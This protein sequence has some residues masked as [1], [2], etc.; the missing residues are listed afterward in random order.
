MQGIL[1]RD[2]REIRTKVVPNVKRETLQTEVLKNV[3]YGSS[4]LHR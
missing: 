4:G 2:A 3:K 1:D